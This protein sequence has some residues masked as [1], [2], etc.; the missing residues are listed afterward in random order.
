M[1]YRNSQCR[2]AIEEWIHSDRDR[3]ILCLRLIHGWTFERIA[4]EVDMSDKQVRR[5]VKRLQRQLFKHL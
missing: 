1:E 4:E 5:I 2:E 3:K